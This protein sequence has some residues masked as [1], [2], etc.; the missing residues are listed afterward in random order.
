MRDDFLAATT[1]GVSGKRK[2]AE[3]E[4]EKDFG[5]EARALAQKTDQARS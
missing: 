5:E 3:A 4:P 1:K 2:A